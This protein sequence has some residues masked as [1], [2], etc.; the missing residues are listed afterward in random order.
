G[1]SSVPDLMSRSWPPPCSTGTGER[2]LPRISAPTPTGPPSL[3]AVTVMASAPERAKSTGSCAA[4]CTA[5][6]GNG[7]PNSWATAASDETGCTAPTSLLAHI[8][9]TTAAEE[10]SVSSAARSTSA[11]TR[12]SASTS[13]Q[14]A[15]APCVL[16]SHRTE[17]NTA[18]CSTAV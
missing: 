2:L 13:S 12:P 15:T 18:W 17:S 5:S 6:G 9:L 7:T 4:A 8:T 10:G 11:P 1:A 16:Q 3:C 14:C